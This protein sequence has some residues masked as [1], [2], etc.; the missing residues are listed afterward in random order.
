[1]VVGSLQG[2]ESKQAIAWRAADS[3]SVR[4]FLGYGLDEAAPRHVTVS[5]TGRLIDSGT[6][7]RVF[8][9]VPAQL[10]RAGLIQGKTIRVDATTLEANAAMRSIV[11]RDAGESYRE[12]LERLAAGAG[13]EAAD[14]AVLRRMDGKRAKQLANAEWVSAHEAEATR[15]RDGRTGLAY[16]VEEA[17]D[18]RSGAI[19][20]VTA[21]GGAAADT[22]TIPRTV[23]AAGEQV[24]ELILV[25]TADGQALGASGRGER[26]GS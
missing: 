23:A 9:W 4:E 1:M 22:E 13:L 21:H 26:S 16:K 24:A 8:A 20:A 3:L 7:Q 19:L 2:L 25:V 12:Y 6:H 10:A 15:L 11:R 17:V 5:R 14:P 18:M